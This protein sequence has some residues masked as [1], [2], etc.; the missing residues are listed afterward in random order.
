V[1]PNGRFQA[2]Q[3]LEVGYPVR[4]GQESDVEDEVRLEWDAELEAKG[5]HLDGHDL[6]G[7]L[8]WNEA[9]DALLQLPD[10]K[11]AR[12]DDVVR[13][14][15]RPREAETLFGDRGLD[16]GPRT[17]RVAAARLGEAAHQHRITRLQEDHE[18]LEAPA[19]QH[20]PGPC[21]GRRWITDADVED[22]GGVAVAIRIRVAQRQE[23][24]EQVRREV[25]DAGIAEILEKLR[26]LALTRP[27][28]AAQDD[29]APSRGGRLGGVRWRRCRTRRG[30]RPRRP[31]SS[32]PPRRSASPGGR[33]CAS[34]HARLP[35]VSS[36]TIVVEYSRARRTAESPD[37]ASPGSSCQA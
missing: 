5:D 28:E 23:G 36:S 29:D 17:E 4:I 3:A 8:A 33:A 18:R 30:S 20:G 31:R 10:R 14:R 34:G 16:A 21:D 35:L 26:R 1:V 2:G 11:A 13:K 15:A 22:E 19:G 37:W 6:R 32:G 25:V 9:P 24:V 27:G 12:V 7:R